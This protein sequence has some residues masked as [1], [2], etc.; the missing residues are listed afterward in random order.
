LL[1]ASA[2]RVPTDAGKAFRDHY[3]P[4]VVAA[5]AGILAVSRHI[6]ASATR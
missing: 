2:E 4:T 5:V 3:H 1:P 6:N